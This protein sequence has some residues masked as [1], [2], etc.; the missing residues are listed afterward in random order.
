V[1]GD[2]TQKSF[3]KLLEHARLE[4]HMTVS[5]LAY[6]TGI[7]DRMIKAFEEGKSCP[8]LATAVYLAKHL[9]LDLNELVN[10]TNEGMH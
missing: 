7:A 4:F 8:S 2:S 9:G 6:E 5:Q 3:G 10:P 1:S